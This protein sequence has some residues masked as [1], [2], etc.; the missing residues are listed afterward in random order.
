MSVTRI[1]VFFVLLLLLVGIVA[2]GTVWF[3][4]PSK[5]VQSWRLPD[6]SEISLAMVTYGQKH[7]MRYDDR[8]Q[9][10]LYPILP[11]NVQAK[12]G[13]RVA[14]HTSSTSNAIVVWIWSRKMPGALPTM[15]ASTLPNY[16]L[17]TVDENGLESKVLFGPNCNYSLSKN[18]DTLSGWELQAFPRGSKQIGIRLYTGGVNGNDTL[19]AEFKIPNRVRVN[20]STSWIAEQLPAT[21]KTNDLEVSLVKLETGLTAD[22]TGMLPLTK[23]ARSFS[24]GEFTMREHGHPTEDWSVTQIE[25]AANSGE[26]HPMGRSQNS[27]RWRNHTNFFSFACALWLEEPAWR[28]KVEVSRTAHFPPTELWIIRDIAVP[29]SGQNNEISAHTNMYGE[30]IEFLGVSSPNAKL[31]QDWTKMQPEANL[32]VRTPFPLSD[33]HLKLVEVRDDQRRKLMTGGFAIRSSTGSRGA[34]MRQMDYGFAVG[35][36]DDAKTLE[37]TFA[38]TQSRYVE[39]L[40]KPVMAEPSA[41]H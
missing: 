33:A 26:I 17:A 7:R 30:E 27:S 4:K 18:G 21:R 29:A 13:S 41:K 38:F 39:F 9:D 14:M 8:W 32:H 5:P 19:I 35:I 40:A 24:V 37:V 11:A 20:R 2:G 6:G 16:Q 22:G 10:V 28:L 36:P 34:T 31:P 23:D 12:F 3:F 25:A 1:R 15:G